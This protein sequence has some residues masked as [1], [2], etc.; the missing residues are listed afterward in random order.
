[1]I[2]NECKWLWMNV[3]DCERIVNDFERMWMIVNECKWLWT[4][5]NDYECMW[6]IVNEC[7]CM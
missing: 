1:M 4:N 5:V 7:E 6:V 3:N 2:A